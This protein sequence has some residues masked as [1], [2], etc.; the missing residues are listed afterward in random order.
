M[1]IIFVICLLLSFEFLV[2]CNSTV[3]DFVSGVAPQ[4][5]P[6]PSSNSPNIPVGL[7]GSY[8][9]ISQGQV[10]ATS[11]TISFNATVGPSQHLLQ[12]SGMSA[13][14]R[15]HSLGAVNK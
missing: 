6:V 11:G 9:R 2:G 12:A 15:L 10:R 4:P 14:I 8:L 5:T 3:T 1:R 7:G 13:S